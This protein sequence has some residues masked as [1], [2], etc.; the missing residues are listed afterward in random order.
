MPPTTA[1]PKLAWNPWGFNTWV[2]LKHAC[3][4]RPST[5]HMLLQGLSPQTS[6]P[7]CSLPRLSKS[8]ALPLLALDTLDFHYDRLGHHHCLP[9]AWPLLGLC[10]LWACTP[11]G[12][13]PEI[14]PQ[15]CSKLG[16]TLLQLNRDGL[17]PAF[18]LTVAESP[19]LAAPRP[20][21]PQAH[22]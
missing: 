12:K 2:C 21:P 10:H 7:V 5:L 16:S 9:L 15:Y 1:A 18:L 19:S 20:L 6:C 4:L 13:I 8:I 17:S 14:F 22:L 11:L 3:S